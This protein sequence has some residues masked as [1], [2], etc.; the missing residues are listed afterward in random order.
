MVMDDREARSGRQPYEKYLARK[1]G[2]E[3]L[4]YMEMR[5]HPRAADCVLDYLA[6]YKPDTQTRDFCRVK[7]MLHYPH[8]HLNK[9]LHLGN[10]MSRF[11]DYQSLHDPPSDYCGE[12]PL[13]KESFEDPEEVLPSDF[14]DMVQELPNHPLKVQDIDI[15]GRRPLNLAMDWSP[16]VGK[17]ARLSANHKKDLEAEHKVYRDVEDT[18]DNV[19]DRLGPGQLLDL[20]YSCSDSQ[21]QG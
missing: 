15:F 3:L 20:A 16:F 8:R 13:A 2:F 18:L 17:Y 1:D 21:S 6:R 4:T 14:D 5:P 12:L 9:L 19:V 10:L 11:P 7:M